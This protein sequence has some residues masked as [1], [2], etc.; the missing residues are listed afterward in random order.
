VKNNYHFIILLQ[1]PLQTF[2]KGLSKFSLTYRGEWAL[3]TYR[4]PLL[5]NFQTMASPQII[6]VIPP[7]YSLKVFISSEL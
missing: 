7:K 1:I 4:I 3:S 2:A 5:K 6:L